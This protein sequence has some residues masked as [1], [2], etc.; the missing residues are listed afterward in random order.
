L[1]AVKATGE[2]LKMMRERL[3]VDQDFRPLTGEQLLQLAQLARDGGQRSIAR[4][5]LTDFRRHYPSDASESAV[6]KLQ[7]DLAR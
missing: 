1:L 7:A 3:A 2:A 5:L 4:Q 6:A